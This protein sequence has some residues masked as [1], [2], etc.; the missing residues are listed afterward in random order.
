MPRASNLLVVLTDGGRARLVARSPDDGRYHTLEEL[1]DGAALKTL[2]E[3]LRATPPTRTHSSASPRRSAVGPEDHVRSAKEAFM[4]EVAHRA[5]EV[6]RTRQ[7]DGVIVAAPARLVGPLREQL[8]GRLTIAGVIAKD[9]TKTP[10]SELSSWL[11]D[12]FTNS[13]SE[14]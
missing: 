3:E 6:G 12:A 5:I 9:L 8:E 14:S 4:G 11:D 10:D 7:A 2:R 1:D 13:P